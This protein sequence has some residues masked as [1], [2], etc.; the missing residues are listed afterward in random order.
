MFGLKA[1]F[2]RLSR[3]DRYELSSGVL[4][5]HRGWFRSENVLLGHVK[6]W[7]VEHEML[8]DVVTLDVGGSGPLRWLDFDND[9]LAILRTHA[10]ELER[11]LRK[12]TGTT[13]RDR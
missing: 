7:H 10:A 13:I 4:I 1:L 9:L 6:S 2:R 3:Q 11:H 8:F 5:R 12:L